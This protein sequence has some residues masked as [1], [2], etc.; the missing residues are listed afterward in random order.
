MRTYARGTGA[1][2]PLRHIE[3]EEGVREENRQG[4]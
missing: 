4:Q 3:A 1:D 2:K